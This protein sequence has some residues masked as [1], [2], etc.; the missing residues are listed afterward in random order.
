MGRLEGNGAARCIKLMKKHGYNEEVKFHIATVS[1][2]SPF[3]IRIPGDSDDIEE[4]SLIVMQSILEHDRTIV[5]DGT[6][7]I[8]TMKSLVNQGDEVFVLE[9]NDGQ[10]YHVIDKVV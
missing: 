2:V 10:L 7:K 4:D 1:S 3:S 8:I 5:I 9:T 6:E